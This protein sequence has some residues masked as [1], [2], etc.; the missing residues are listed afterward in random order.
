MATISTVLSSSRGLLASADGRRGIVYWFATLTIGWELIFGGLW[1]FLH[2]AYVVDIV[3][4]DLHYPA[5][6]LTILGFWKVLGGL[7]LLAP[8]LPRLK[9]WA[10]AGAFFNY[11]GAVASY[12]FVGAGIDRWWGPAGF[13]VILLASWALRPPSRRDLPC[14]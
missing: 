3:E 2:V 9:E 10:Y 12:L 14:T 11:T 4:R 8:R 13:A 6:V 1:D 7:A 5:Y